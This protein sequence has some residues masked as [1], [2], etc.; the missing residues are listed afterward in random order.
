V[1]LLRAPLKLAAQQ[2]SAAGAGNEPERQM[3][4]WRITPPFARAQIEHEMGGSVEK[5]EREACEQA[6]NRKRGGAIESHL[7]RQCEDGTPSGNP[8]QEGGRDAGPYDVAEPRR[9]DILK[10][11]HQT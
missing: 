4:P 3:F 1:L 10:R 2:P 8:E 11:E 6:G 5:L 7:G 9:A